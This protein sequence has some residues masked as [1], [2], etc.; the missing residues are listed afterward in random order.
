MYLVL[1]YYISSSII[2]N[3]KNTTQ[4]LDLKHFIFEFLGDAQ[5]TQ[6]CKKNFSNIK[7]FMRGSPRKK[8]QFV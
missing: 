8:A 7:L 4:I 6:G 5:E 2:Q 3:L 1:I